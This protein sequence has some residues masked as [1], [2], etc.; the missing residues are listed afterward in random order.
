MCPVISKSIPI[1]NYPSAT[2]CLCSQSKQLSCE[3]IRFLRHYKLLK[4]HLKRPKETKWIYIQNILYHFLKVNGAQKVSSLGLL[5]Q[6]FVRVC[7]YPEYKLLSN[8]ALKSARHLLYKLLLLL[9]LLLL[10]V[11]LLLLYYY[12][13]IVIII[14]A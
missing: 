7:S 14:V 12:Y 10:L 13:I 1:I 4:V 8:C 11:I 3:Y 6:C 9:L 2:Q 5:S